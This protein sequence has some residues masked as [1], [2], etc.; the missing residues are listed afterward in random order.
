MSIWALKNSD[1]FMHAKKQGSMTLTQGLK[2]SIGSVLEE[3]CTLDLLD[4]DFK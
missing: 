2:Q 4:K 3:A 1:T